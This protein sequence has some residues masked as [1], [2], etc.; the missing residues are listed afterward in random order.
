MLEEELDHRTHKVFDASTTD[1]FIPMRFDVDSLQ[2]P[3]ALLKSDQD[4]FDLRPL[5]GFGAGFGRLGGLALLPFVP[6]IRS[7][8]E[9]YES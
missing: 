6:P 1:I 4:W 8:R 2:V 3:N 9:G 7:V 5:R